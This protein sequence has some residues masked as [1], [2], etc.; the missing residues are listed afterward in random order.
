MADEMVR[1]AQRFINSYD[2]PGIPKVEE[3]G[4]TSW[5]VMFALT[6]ALQ[7]E[8]GITALS[9]SFGATTLSTLQSRFGPQIDDL[10]RHGNVYRIVQ[11]GLY[12]KGYDGGG[13]DGSY[14]SQVAESVSAL[15]AD[16]GIAGAYPG[17]ALEPK[18]FKALLTMDPYVVVG[19]GTEQ[20]RSIQQWLNGRY[21]HRRE[22]F[23][24]PCD[25]HFSRDVQK[26]LIFA[27]QYEIGM[28]D[29]VANGRFGPGTQD[30]IRSQAMLG[31]GASDTTKQ[32]VRL[33][34]A[35]MRF[36]GWD[37]AFDGHYSGALADTVS[38]F[39]QF[40]HLAPTGG[41]ADFRTWASLLVSTGDPTRPGTACDCVTEIT[42][43]RAQALRAAGY[44]T[45][46]RYLTNAS[47]PNARN[48]KIQPGELA[49]IV[50]GGLSVFPIYQTN[51]GDRE[52]FSPQRGALDA[53]AALE[54]AREHG[55]QAGTIIYFAVDYDAV[56]EEVTSRVI[57][58]FRA[59]AS[60]MAHYGS[61]YRVGVY[62]P[63]NICSRLA[64]AGLTVSSF[65]S[66][67]STAYS[68]NMGFPLPRDWAFDQIST[69]WVGADAGRIEIDNDIASG[70]DP[71]QTQFTPR[72]PDRALDVYFD[73]SHQDALA[74]DLV[75]YIEDNGHDDWYRARSPEECAAKV[76]DLDPLITGLARSLRMRKALM[77]AVIFWEYQADITDDAADLAVAAHYRWRESFE[78]W[79][80]NPIG[81]APPMPIPA[82][83]DSSTGVAQIFAK[84]A[85]EARNH[86]VS[87]GLIPGAPLDGGD[88][89]VFRDVWKALR[90]DED[91]NV[92]TVAL[93]HIHSAH[94]KGV[95]ADRLAYTA[96]DTATVLARYNG[97]NDDATQYGLRAR[98]LYDIFERYNAPLRTP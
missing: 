37:V 5:T 43:A 68:G 25:G 88:W 30:G 22:F 51:G 32:F 94:R 35:A 1:L 26:A 62:A 86:A 82:V 49:T 56:D 34:Q 36:N 46:G 45:V 77:Q 21:V 53:L 48:K 11:S 97:T 63:R 40:A 12:C 96:A 10:T 80:Q 29:D 54:A 7:H 4:R 57:P 50:A 83:E 41:S 18:V 58:H 61:E 90:D 85:I 72:A 74:R 65:V 67:M 28:G 2:V 33:F 9:D 14:N 19:D 17:G 89:H 24:C 75:T 31:V 52:Y 64:Q 44:T 92:S 13:I 79:E 76:M 81:P 6:R 70:R 60:R 95:T 47:V 55:F 84:T 42:P 27:L 16:M 3:N 78:A 38:R 98:D 59:L 71:G 87:Q 91:Y 39:Q 66:D 73:R 20:V 8:L 23:I 93:V 69:I 15:K